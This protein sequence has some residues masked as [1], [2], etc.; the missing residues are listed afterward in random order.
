M[1]LKLETIMKER[2][3]VAKHYRLYNVINHIPLLIFR[4]HTSNRSN[5]QDLLWLNSGCICLSFKTV[6]DLGLYGIYAYIR[7][8]DK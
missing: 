3:P 8:E 7:L 1:L 2:Y 4:M 5:T 6:V